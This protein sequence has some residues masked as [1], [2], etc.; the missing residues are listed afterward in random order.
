[1]IEFQLNGENIQ[2]TG[3]PQKNLLTYLRNEQKLTAPKGGCSGEGIC[4][5]CLIE[6]DGKPVLACQKAI[7]EINGLAIYTLEGIPPKTREVIATTFV[8]KGAVQCGFC[9]PGFV[10]RTHLLLK[11][12]PNP[13]YDEIQQA[14]K[15]HLCR[16]TGYKKIEKAIEHSALQLSGK[17]DVENILPSGAVGTS[18]PKYNGLKTALGES[19]FATDLQF[20]GMLYGALHFS[21]HPRAKVIA[22]DTVLAKTMPGVKGVF[23]ARDVPGKRVTGLFIKDWPLMI[24]VGE[25]THCIGDVLAGVVAETEEQARA[26][27]LAIKVKYVIYDPI[28]DPDAAMLKDSPQVHR[29]KPNLLETCRHVKGDADRALKDADFVISGKYTTPRVEHAFLETESSVAIWKKGGITLYTSGQ[30]IYKDRMQLARILNMRESR[31]R[32]VHVPPGGAFGGKEDIIT[33]GFASLFAKLLK[34]TV[35]VTLNRQESIRMHPKRHPVTLEITLACDN[36]GV[37]TAMKMKAIG[38]TGAYASVGP[39]VLERIASHAS[40]GYFIPNIDIQAY[41]VYTNN[42]PSGVM[43]GSGASQ[44]IFAL[45]SCIDEL[46]RLGEFDRWQFRYDNALTEGLTT[47]SGDHVKA[48]GIIPCL[49]ALKEKFYAHQYVGLACAIKNSGVGNGEKDYSPVLIEIVSADKVLMHHGWS[50]LGQG[51]NTLAIQMFCQETEIDAGKVEII[52]DTASGVKTG[53]ST[54]SREAILLGNAIIDACRKLKKDIKKYGLAKLAGRKYKGRWECHWTRKPWNRKRNGVTHYSY[55][56]AAQLVVL[57]NDGNIEKIYAAQDVGNN[58]N[59]TL[60][61]G[62]IEGAVHM[63][64]G[65]ALTEELPMKD[66]FPAINSLDECKILRA[67][68]TPPIEVIPVEIPD[69]VGPYGLKGYDEIGSVPTTAALANAWCKF[70]GIRR[71]KMPLSPIKQKAQAPAPPAL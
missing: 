37:L 38:D 59:P 40:G 24:D 48:V 32:V 63:G 44:A 12:N 49:E 42:V 19:K 50:E 8:N 16:C 13:S 25:T 1:M 52:V 2:Y 67:H 57:D 5:A 28:T 15:G 46:C 31:I 45:E 61:E 53:M 17:I 70:D 62:R 69:P 47:A 54:S 43:C 55:G 11:E 34:S 58:M 18:T 27:V 22:I 60:M 41:T 6:A 39:R 7:G 66:G 56:Y 4:G 26:A 64:L 65:Y 20:D 71:Y 51:V 10:M 29:K 68:Q 30:G 21:P 35:K 23:T 14:I 3:E 9:T 33:Q 36:S